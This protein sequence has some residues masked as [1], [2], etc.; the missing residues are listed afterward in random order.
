MHGIHYLTEGRGAVAARFG[1]AGCACSCTRVEFIGPADQAGRRVTVVVRVY[2]GGV[3]VPG[4]VWVPTS[5]RL[6]RMT[7]PT[8]PVRL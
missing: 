6:D 2:D 7:G 3:L 8:V 5:R 1:A 4:W